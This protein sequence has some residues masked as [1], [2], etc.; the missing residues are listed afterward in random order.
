MG[1]TAAPSGDSATTFKEECSAVSKAVTAQTWAF[2]RWVPMPDERWRDAEG[3]RQLTDAQQDEIREQHIRHGCTV[4]WPVTGLEVP[5]ML[6]A[7]SISPLRVH[8]NQRFKVQVA[9]LPSFR[10]SMPGATVHG[11]IFPSGRQQPFLRE[12]IEDPAVYLSKVP[13][14]MPS[15]TAMAVLGEVTFTPNCARNFKDFYDHGGSGGDGAFF[16]WPGGDAC[17]ICPA[18]GAKIAPDG[19]TRHLLVAWEM[20]GFVT[21]DG[22]LHMAY[23]IIPRLLTRAG[24]ELMMGAGSHRCTRGVVDARGTKEELPFFLPRRKTFDGTLGVLCQ[25]GT[26]APPA[27]SAW[28]HVH[29]DGTYLAIERMLEDDRRK[30]AKCSN[31]D[32][33][34]GDI[35]LKTEGRSSGHSEYRQDK[36]GKERDSQ[37]PASSLSMAELKRA[38]ITAGLT[39]DDC[40]EKADVLQRYAEAQEKRARESKD[41]SD[42]KAPASSIKTPQPK[43]QP[44]LEAAC[45]H[46]GA[47]GHK[48]LLCSKCVVAGRAPPA[49]YCSKECQKRA[50]P[51]HKT[52]CKRLPIGSD[53]SLGGGEKLC[54]VCKVTSVCTTANEKQTA[55]IHYCCGAEICFACSSREDTADAMNCPNCG[56]RLPTTDDET[57]EWIHKAATRGDPRAQLNLGRALDEG[58]LSLPINHKEAARWIRKAAEQGHPKAEYDLG[59]CYRDG[60]G[61]VADAAEARK[62]FH[63]AALQCHVSAQC[64]LGIMLVQASLQGEMEQLDAAQIWLQKAAD[65]GDELASREVRRLVKLKKKVAEAVGEEIWMGTPR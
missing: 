64:N 11:L 17:A 18:T 19:K 58:H 40:L 54:P 32:L 45:S 34:P 56:E 5:E 15:Q 61:V 49:A 39:H 42:G 6:R 9:E 28:N 3:W 10:M 38:I 52:A 57:L 63:R 21:N 43:P 60:E 13:L 27:N 62:W 44:Q 47:T 50:W 1:N 22:A 46:C 33:G 41:I 8:P 51:T 36:S 37:G 59:V 12:I 7:P 55:T 31:K 26:Q 14:H 4:P 23:R 29:S 53:I 20:G 65:A 48:L 25:W 2:R 35:R 16:A 30:Q 24:Y